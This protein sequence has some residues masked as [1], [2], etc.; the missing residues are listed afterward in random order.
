MAIAG[1]VAPIPKGEWNSAVEY[2]KLD[3][4]SYNNKSFMAKTTSQNHTPVGDS[5]DLYWMLL[6]EGVT[7][8]FTGA[9][10]SSDGTSG[11]VPA[12]L[13]GEQKK[14]LKGDGTWSSV[15]IDEVVPTTG[16]TAGQIPILEEVGG[17]LKFAVTD[18]P[19][20][21]HT[22]KNMN[23]TDM[24]QRASMQFADAGVTDDSTN[25]KTVVKVV[26]QMTQAQYEALS[27][28]EKQGVIEITNATNPYLYAS[29]V[30]TTGGSNVEDELEDKADKTDIA[31]VESGT[32][33]SRAYSVG[34]LVYVSGTLYRVKT[35]IASGATFT[36]GTN[37]E[38]KNVSDV[39]KNNI[40]QTVVT[41]TFPNGSQN[42]SLG[43]SVA[44]YEI[45]SITTHADG[46]ILDL[47][48]D[49]TTWCVG[50]YNIVRQP[51]TS[52]RTINIQVFYK[53]RN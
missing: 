52:G 26:R 41:V 35:A 40:Q 19:S 53:L 20:S 49:S 14:V 46:I 50:A 33:A 9:T 7:D 5:Q 3:I 44:T 11:V 6:I 30:R 10:A 12:P 45:I 15:N 8:A 31:T 51:I 17:T 16:A 27:S 34:E 4:V 25:D 1:R 22:I 28:L 32:T 2:T 21:G 18:I 47:W 13:T 29:Q 23:G 36:V 39:I 43:L 37:I 42:V 48:N 38:A 24:T